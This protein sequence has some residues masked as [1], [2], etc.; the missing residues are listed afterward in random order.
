MGENGQFV[1]RI[2]RGSVDFMEAEKTTIDYFCLL[3]ASILYNGKVSFRSDNGNHKY[4]SRI[5]RSGVQNV[6]AAKDS[7][8]I[9]SQFTVEVDPKGKWDGAAYLYLKADNDKYV[10]IQDR[11]GRHNLEA[12]FT[13]QQDAT[14]FTLLEVF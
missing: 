2:R 12:S 1:S 3:R 13:S 10:G 7:I 9:F 4:L 14:R 5:F 6:E 11:N 8:D